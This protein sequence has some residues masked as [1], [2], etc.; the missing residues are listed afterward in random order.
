MKSYWIDTSENLKD[1]SSLTEDISADICVIGA[2]MFGLTTAYYLTKKGFNVVIIDKNNIG[3]KASGYTT[4]KI[5]SQHGLIY[6]YLIESFGIDFARKYLNANQ[7]AINN[8]KSIID[9]EN[10]DCDFEYQDNFV[11]TNDLTELP[12]I[13]KEVT[14]VNSL[15]FNAQ[16]VSNIEL[17]IK[18]LGAIKFPNQ[19]QFHPRKYMLGLANC[20]LQNKGKIFINTTATNVKQD[21]NGYIVYTNK[22]KILSKYVVLASHYPFI[23]IPGFYFTK[24]YQDTS[25]VI[26]V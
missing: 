16:F 8:I 11:Y 24:M 15:N 12:K 19:A 13:E 3:G 9:T 6:N 1:L 10:I 2:G 18:N 4:A 7:D 5:T 21:G 22:N 14:A 20:I 23:N 25:Y 17:P 26:G